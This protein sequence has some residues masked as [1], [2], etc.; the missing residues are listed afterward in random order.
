MPGDAA[1]KACYAVLA[2]HKASPAPGVGS[3]AQM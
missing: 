3:A 1:V 2:W